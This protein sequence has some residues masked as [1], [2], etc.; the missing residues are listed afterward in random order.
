MR[1][2]GFFFGC[3]LNFGHENCGIELK[4]RGTLIRDWKVFIEQEKSARGLERERSSG[5]MV[6]ESNTREA[7]KKS[8]TSDLCPFM[9]FEKVKCMKYFEI[10]WL[11][12]LSTIAT[13]IKLVLWDLESA[14]RTQIVAELFPTSIASI[15]SAV[16]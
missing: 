12:F 16:N 3:L 7:R 14:D 15:F 5:T 8:V 6:C 2:G 13:S 9:V 1:W 10:T 4:K 11:F